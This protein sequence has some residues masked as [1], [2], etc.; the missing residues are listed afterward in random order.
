MLLLRRCFLALLLLVAAPLQAAG[1]S[2]WFYKNSDIAPDPAWTFGTLPNGLRYAVRRNALPEGQVSVRLRIDAGSLHESDEERGWAHFIEHMAFR[3]TKNLADGEVRETWQRLGAS[4][5]SDTNASTEPTQT[6]YMLDLPHADRA[7]L[8]TSLKLLADMADTA[9]FEP[10]VV[11]MERGVVL[12]EYGRRTELAVKLRDIMLP[13]FFGGLKFAERDTI[14]TEATLKAATASGL[15]A[16]YERWYRPERATLVMVGDADP[17]LM[18]ALIAERFGGWK[19][20]G[21][22]PTE[23]EYGRIADVREPTAALAY[24]GSP[25]FA[26]L[27]WIRPYTPVP[28]TKAREQRDLARSLARRILNRRLEAKA[29]GDAAF[30]NAQVQAEESV[31][32]ADYTQLSVMAKEGRWQEA[33]SQ[34]YA[35][36]ADA[37]K[38]PPSEAEIGRELENIRTAGRAALQGDPTQRSQQ[39]AGRMINALDGNSVISS[40]A[41][42]LDLF[43]ALAPTMTPAAVEAAMRDL[44]TGAGPRLAMLS[45]APVTGLAQALAAAEA[46][47]PAER[48]AE[49]RVSMDELPPLGAPGREVSRQRIADLDS[50]IVRFANGS[51]LVF[52]QTDF[53]KGNVSVTLRFGR[54]MA[55]LPADAK[56]LAWLGP[57]LGSTGVGPFDL[58]G[59]E[60][61]LTGRRLSMSFGIAE[62]ALEL[63][64]TTRAEEL[65]DQLR[66]LTTKI[67]APH[68]DAAL[69][70]RSKIAALE[71]YELAFS[72]AS[73]RIGREFAAVARGGDPRW[74]AWD[75]AEIEK[76]TAADFEAFMTPLL[77][78]GPVEAIVVGDVDLET[79]VAAML[80]TVAALPARADVAPP[81]ASLKVRPPRPSKEPIRF[82]HQGDPAQAYAALAWTTFGGPEHRRERRALSVAA[83]IAQARLIERLRDSEGASYSPAATVQSSFDFPDWGLFFAGSEIRP[84]RADLFFRLARGIVAELAA[85]PASAD[86]WQRAINPVV[87]GIERR[88]RTNAY[89]A[90]TM[91]DWSREPWLIDYTRTYLAD[92][93]SLTPDE[94]RRATAKWVGDEG[95]W[96]ILVLPAKTPD[97]VH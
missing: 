93:K 37:L 5:G 35:I 95:D 34:A 79:A 24:P 47:T 75:K 82:T 70:Q 66:L 67:V 1:D 33:L 9:A 51:S 87:T 52:K 62:D 85:K 63:R 77:A 83:N 3:G 71:N 60:R 96:S 61:L 50:T 97:S 76:V 16:F 73:S 41:V 23:P 55:G 65:G 46:A 81:P 6:V 18:E 8:D 78:Q 19:G 22:A 27:S 20:S 15:K 28:P 31:N 21:P 58:D 53:E 54:G 74:Q 32:V 92:Y 84:E 42:Q 72:S 38:A 44:F 56:S 17:K 64:G 90:G 89:W 59:L 94:V 2:S 30:L 80:K 49:R 10:K 57:L 7:S 86:E 4:F 91:E 26:T 88:L 11:D 14:G 25:H 29:R 39:R 12:S 45:P 36:L 40:A 48:Q 13:L 43:E 69:F 68:F